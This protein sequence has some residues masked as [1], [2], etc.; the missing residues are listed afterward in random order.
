MLRLKTNAREQIASLHR[1]MT[2]LMSSQLQMGKKCICFSSRANPSFRGVFWRVGT[3]KM[4]LGGAS[5]FGAW[6]N[7]STEN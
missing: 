1:A 5:Q 6:E 4:T 2:T 3:F 7:L